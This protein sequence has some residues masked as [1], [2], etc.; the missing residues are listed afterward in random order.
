LEQGVGL[1]GSKAV[2]ERIEFLDVGEPAGDFAELSLRGVDVEEVATVGSFLVFADHS[3]SAG[4]L[5]VV[6]DFE[7]TH[8]LL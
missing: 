3:T 4:E 8:R 2:D 6:A 1:A 5:D 7:V